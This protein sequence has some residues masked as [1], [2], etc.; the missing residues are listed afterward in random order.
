VKGTEFVTSKSDIL[1]KSYIWLC[2]S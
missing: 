1:L 2:L